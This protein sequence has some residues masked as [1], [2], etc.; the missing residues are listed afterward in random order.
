MNDVKNE[1]LEE[2]AKLFMVFDVESIGLH[3]EWFSVGWCIIDD[4]GK[5]IASAQYACDPSRAYGPDDGRQW[6]SENIPVP[7]LG[8]NCPSPRAV[9]DE[10]W[11]AWEYAKNRGAVLV[12]DCPWPVEAGFLCQCIRDDPDR[13]W[14]GPYPFIDVASVRLAVGLDPLETC[15]R[16]PE[17]LPVHDPLCDAMQ[18]ARLLI[19]AL[20]KHRELL[21]LRKSREAGDEEVSSLEDEILHG[22]GTDY[23][24]DK[25]GCE[26][27]RQALSSLV[28]IA[29][30][31]RRQNAEA[32]RRE[33]VMAHHCQKYVEMTWE[34]AEAA[35]DA[36]E[37]VEISREEIDRI[38]GLV[39]AMNDEELEEKDLRQQIRERDAEIERLKGELEEEKA[40][41][42]ELR[43]N[44]GEAGM[45]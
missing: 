23:F 3:G 7:N 40:Y 36:A 43:E 28:D 27:A 10:F 20:A 11:R 12:A 21:S 4:A 31:L 44:F 38:V 45:Y 24:E 14:G 29:I 25:K 35:Y 13:Y 15:E 42:K 39:T 5:T 33:Q 8:Y 37:P 32:K 22:I 17:E 2:I 6:A 9:R 19:E 16:N 34:Q 41:S 18:S 26:D 1:R 30:S